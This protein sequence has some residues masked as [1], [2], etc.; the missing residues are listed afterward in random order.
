MAAE[1]DLP[2]VWLPLPPTRFDSEVVVSEIRPPHVGPPIEELNRQLGAPGAAK[3]SATFTADPLRDWDGRVVEMTRYQQSG[4]VKFQGETATQ[5]L[6]RETAECSLSQLA[7]HS[8]DPEYFAAT[9]RYAAEHGDSVKIDVHNGVSA[10]GVQETHL[11]ADY[12]GKSEPDYNTTTHRGD[13]EADS[14]N[15]HGYGPFQLDDRSHSLA[16][17]QRAA[18]DP[19]FAADKAA[20][21]LADNIASAKTAGSADPIS[22]AL[23]V[24]NAGK[25]STPSSPTDWGPDIGS[26]PSRVQ[27]MATQPPR[28]KEPCSGD[29]LVAE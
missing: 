13:V 2:G 10:V 20:S 5:Q 19:Y 28:W 23:H 6:G 14:P 3:P 25:L 18:S 26:L 27:E 22:D 11:G 16:D 12:L 1:D 9:L 29:V 24:Y 17:L 7:A 21:M 15:G 8:K 4:T